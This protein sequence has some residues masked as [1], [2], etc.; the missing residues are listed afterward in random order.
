M[1]VYS[2][3]IRDFTVSTIV[4]FV[5][6]GIVFAFY[7]QYYYYSLLRYRPR[8]RSRKFSRLILANAKTDSRS[9]ALDDNGGAP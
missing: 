9:T 4:D 6:F 8:R 2:V 3:C 5:E 7:G 1:R